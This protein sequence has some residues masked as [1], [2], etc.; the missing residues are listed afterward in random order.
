L[1]YPWVKVT[2]F[3]FRPAVNG[4]VTADPSP[5]SV[6]L[7][8]SHG[9]KTVATLASE[10]VFTSRSFGVTGQPARLIDNAGRSLAWHGAVG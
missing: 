5:D 1:Q 4:R 7:L 9:E 8:A 10:E 3:R 2:V 6:V